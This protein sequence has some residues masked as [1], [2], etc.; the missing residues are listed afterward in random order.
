MSSTLSDYDYPLPERL[1]AQRPLPRR[2][3]SRMMVLHRG[4]HTVE[5]RQFRELKSFLKPGDLLVL[6]D[7]RVLAARRFS[8]DDAVEFLFI[9][10][11]GPVRWRCLVKPG[12]K[13]RIGATAKIDNVRLRVEEILPDGERIVSPEKDVDFH[14]GGSIPLPPYIERESDVEDEMRYQTI[15]AQPPGA[16]AAP[17]AGFH[18]TREILNE[19]PHAF[20]TLH[21]GPGTFRPVQSENILEHKMHPEWLCVSAVAADKI[22]KAKRVMAVGTTT[23]RVLESARRENGKLIAQTGSTDIFIY[24]PYRFQHVDLLFTN[25]HLPKSTLLMLVS[26]FAGREF[27]LR[28]YEEAICERYRF[29]SYGDCMLIL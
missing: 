17:T 9:E 29:Y 24:P 5:H 4:W 26:A 15:F 13:M 25:F 27:I 6:N 2:E 20:V 3:D 8:D 16:L 18:F 22:N 7:T 28:A 11:L 10:K 14:C 21:V 1:I 12:R 23:V 19:I